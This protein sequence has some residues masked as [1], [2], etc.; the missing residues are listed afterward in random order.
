[1]IFFDTELSVYIVATLFLFSESRKN[2]S[3]FTE[4]CL[5]HVITGALIL[6][7]YGRRHFNYGLLV[8]NLHDVTDLFLESS[9]TINYLCGDPWSVITFITFA[10]AFFYTRLLVF[11]KYLILPI[12]NGVASMYM[13]MH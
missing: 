9:K 3:D 11:P 8:A 13:D 5:H 7:G 10:I 12:I 6:T 1:M 4:M 2:N